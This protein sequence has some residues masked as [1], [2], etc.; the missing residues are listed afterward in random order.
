MTG[1]AQL[2]ELP[3]VDELLKRLTSLTPRFPRELV[4]TEVRRVLDEARERIQAGLAVDLAELDQTVTANL[5]AIERPSLR[6]VIN[7]TGVVLHTNLGRAPLASFEPIDGYS[8]L[9][10][11]L[12][13]GRRG[14][15]DSH[16]GA[17]LERLTGRPAIAVNNNAAAVY[18]ALNELAAGFEV[19]V[20]RGELIEIGDGFRI[21]DIM[22]R[23]GAVL[24]EVGTT[25]KTSLD[26]YRSAINERTRLIMRVHPSNFRMEGFTAKPELRALAEL[27][28]ER[29]LPL[30]EDLGSGCVIDLSRFGLSEP[31]VADSLAAGVD[32]VSFSTDKML[33]GPQAGVLAGR[34]DLVARLRR[35][36]MFRAFRLDKLITQALEDTLRNLVLRRWQEVPA[37][38]MLML[39]QDEI[40]ERAARVVGRISQK[41][42]LVDG[43]SVIGG[44][45][46]PAQSMPTCLIAISSDDVMGL[47]RRLRSGEPAVIAR[48]EDRRLLLDLRTVLDDDEL[49]GA[50]Q[51][52]GE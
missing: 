27:A 12:V 21:P 49:A 45:S 1:A 8:N 38:R 35:N 7:A 24:R 48:I 18:L 37:L 23:S 4:V 20:S 17:L 15:R 44:G 28:K 25:N 42:E 6:R 52:A 16:V 50:L 29:G 22:M 26:D 46:T 39:T 41:A 51:G 19:I 47:E 2:R 33:G 30:Y 34:Q 32:I 3:S 36:P 5:D 40:R 11:D 43:E 9:E 13:A 31:V 14:K 10:Y